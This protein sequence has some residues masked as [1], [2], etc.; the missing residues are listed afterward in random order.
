MI[1][2]V[3]VLMIAVLTA[4]DQLIKWI[5]EKNLMPVGRMDFIPNFIEWKYVENTGAAFGSLSNNTDLLSIFTIIIILVCFVVLMSGK[6]KD[7]FYYICGVLIVSG[8]LGNLIDR[9]FRGDKLL[10]GYVIDY[11]NLLFMDFAVF[12]FADCLICIGCIMM[13][14]YVIFEDKIKKKKGKNRD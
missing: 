2:V 9:I 10:N 4:V 1:R 14:I 7:K 5:V 12:N 8:G 13:I 3:S 6:I 11:I